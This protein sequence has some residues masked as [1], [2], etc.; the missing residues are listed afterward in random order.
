MQIKSRKVVYE[1]PIFKIEEREV[2][3]PSN[4]AKTFWTM[5]RPPNVGVVALT[6][7][8]KIVLIKEILGEDSKECLLIPGGKVDTYDYTEEDVK[9]QALTELHEEAGY[10][11]KNIQLLTKHSAP[12]NTIDRYF[13]HYVAWD[14][15]DVGQSL[16][17]GESINRFL[18]TLEEAEEIIK[19][20]KMTSPEEE[21]ILEKAIKFFK[22]K[23]LLP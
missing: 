12:W 19:Q 13:F 17:D 21:R 20:R 11:P 7:D 2:L 22:E 10:V 15:E 3:L 4:V 1:C 14:L 18:V 5:I 6:N 8:K 16:E 9:E 23:G